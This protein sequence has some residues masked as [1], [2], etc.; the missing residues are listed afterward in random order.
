[1]MSS[2]DYFNLYDIKPRDFESAT[3]GSC[4]FLSHHEGVIK[5]TIPSLFYL[6]D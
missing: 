2:Y 4:G 3:E 6:Y 5:T 1:M